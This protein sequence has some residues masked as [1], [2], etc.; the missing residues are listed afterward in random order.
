MHLSFIA[1]MLERLILWL[2]VRLNNGRNKL[3]MG[4]GCAQKD[5]AV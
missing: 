3:E 4:D 1:F 5:K 2:A